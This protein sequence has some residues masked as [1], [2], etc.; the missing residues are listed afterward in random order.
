MV[1]L[2]NIMFGLVYNYEIL[3]DRTAGKFFTRGKG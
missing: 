3:S 1:E 2:F